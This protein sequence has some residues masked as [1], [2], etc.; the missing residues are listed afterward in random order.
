MS[1]LSPFASPGAR[2]EHYLVGFGRLTDGLG[3]VLRERLGRLRHSRAPITRELL[4]VRREG[5]RMRDVV[6]ARAERTR[7]LAGRPAV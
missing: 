4:T 2:A 3:R 5:E 1:A 6:W 7:L